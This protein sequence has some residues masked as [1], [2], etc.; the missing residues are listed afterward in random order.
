MS[1]YIQLRQNT[2]QKFSLPSPMESFVLKR[3]DASLLRGQVVY[4][5]QKCV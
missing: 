4:H 2:G 1:P 3:S 5:F